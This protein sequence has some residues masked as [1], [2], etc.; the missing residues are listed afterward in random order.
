M[1]ICESRSKR[2][3]RHGVI[4]EMLAVRDEENVVRGERRVR[5]EEGFEI[6][7]SGGG[8]GRGRG[9]ELER[10]LFVAKSFD[11]EERRVKG[12]GEEG[13]GEGRGVVRGGRRVQMREIGGGGRG[14]GVVRVVSRGG[15]D[16]STGCHTVGMRV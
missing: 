15:G 14:G 12:R 1:I 3:E 8:G 2:Q 6:I 4:R 11:S 5:G 16:D 13:G 10:D 7:E 9:G